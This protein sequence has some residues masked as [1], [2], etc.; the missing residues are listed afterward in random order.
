MSRA[1][2]LNKKTPDVAGACVVYVMAR[3]QR[4]RDNH[5]LLQ[6]QRA[7]IMHELPLVVWFNLL[8][9]GN[10]RYREHYEFMLEGLIDVESQLSSLGISMRIAT[11]NPR[12]SMKRMLE[13]LKPAE[14]FFDFSP[15]KGPR[16]LQKWAALRAPCRVS[17]VDTHNLIPLWILSDKLEF[18][19][20]TLRSKVHKKLPGWLAEPEQV[21][22]HPYA[23]HETY[24]DWQ[25]HARYIKKMSSNG[26]KLDTPSGEAAAQ[27]RLEDFLS[28]GLSSYALRRNNPV[29][30]GQ[31]GLSPYLHFGQIS[32]LRVALDVINSVGEEPLLLRQGKLASFEGDPTDADGM[33]AFLEELI[34]RKELADNYCF[35]RP[36][37]R[38]LEG[39]W[40]WAKDTLD[41]HKEDV[42][43][44]LYTK[45]QWETSSTH[46]PAWNA[47][48][49]Q[50]VGTG[51][52]H[53][54][55]RMYWAKKL[56]EWSASPE[57]AI[58]IAVYLNDKYSLDGRDPNGYTG[59]MWSIAGVHDRPW[60]DRDV[61]GKIRYMNKSGL[62]KRFDLD[63]YIN[64]WN[65]SG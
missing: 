45:E 21:T 9:E 24:V 61:Y 26:Q 4:V 63:L 35:Y 60:F 28:K 39:A 48:Q 16:E 65:Q 14:I 27:S 46:D 29:D 41:A 8:P 23:S 25:E 62:K 7:A 40:D 10:G 51:K 47:A 37:Y 58:D 44:Y 31:S 30:D 36:D 33:D 6:A 34:V 5:A 57:E 11:G 22:A 50:M 55:M 53:G 1:L 64:T 43:E 15:L 19:A 3:D 20:H 38:Q 52:M 18:A 2:E 49:S 17:V 12:E 13:A 59:I 42:R 56:L 32:A 54:Y